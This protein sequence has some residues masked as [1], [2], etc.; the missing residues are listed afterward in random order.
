V[1]SFLQNQHLLPVLVQL[2]PAGDVDPAAQVGVGVY[3]GEALLPDEL[4]IGAVALEPV[5]PFQAYLDAGKMQITGLSRKM[6]GMA[7][8][9]HQA[10]ELSAAITAADNNRFSI[11]LSQGLQNLLTEVLEV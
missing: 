7:C 4:V 6:L 2:S 5:K 10:V 8:A 11:V 3:P 1:F 9:A